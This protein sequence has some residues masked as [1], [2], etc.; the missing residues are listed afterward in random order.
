MK[1]MKV[2]MPE[3]MS[4]LFKIAPRLKNGEDINSLWNKI[5][6][7]SIDYGLL[8]KSDNI[9]VVTAKF[10]WNDIGSWRALYDVFNKN[11][12]GNIIRGDGKII[13]GTNNFIHS[14]NR[15][16]AIIGLDNII[17]V[18]TDDATLIVDKSKVEDVK[19]LVKFLQKNKMELI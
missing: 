19:E 12:E 14:K 9:Y 2:Y 17:A 4:I 5:E 15:F 16:T 7:Q 13:Q 3:L 8:E 1:C 6:P 10:K 11:S 18:N